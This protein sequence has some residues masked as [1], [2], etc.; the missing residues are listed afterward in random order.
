MA[1]ANDKSESAYIHGTEPQEQARLSLLN[2][3]LNQRTVHELNLQ[4]GE[5]ILDVGS[6]LGQLSRAMARLSGVP[7]V[8]V[9]RSGE[10]IAEALRQA[11]EA[12]ERSLVA[13]RQGDALQLPLSDDEWG[14]FDVAHTRFVL[15]HLREPLCAVQAMVRAV[16]P[17]GRI[18]LED[19]DHDLLR[20]FPQPPGFDALWDA[21]QGSYSVL[22]N[23]AAIGRRL[24]SLLVEA[25]AEPT[26]N[27]FIF[28][29]SCAGEPHFVHYVDN[30][31]AVIQGARVTVLAANLL[32]AESF[33]TAILTLR[34][35]SRE[36]DAT[37][38]YA[39]SW[40]EGRR[41]R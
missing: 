19:D 9:E 12:G 17:G 21:Y 14:S 30:L 20:L 33:D 1:T 41:P 7:V 22:G 4:G 36:R 37:I 28:F 2:D 11:T 26:R 40:A 35:W 31:A 38:W 27:T 32:D 24:V 8:G 3:L 25:G 29:G 13:F 23:D 34:S 16:K 15:E 39:V 5:R 10:Q 18:V 6:G